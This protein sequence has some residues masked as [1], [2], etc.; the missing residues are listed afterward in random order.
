MTP[1]ASPS[2]EPVPPRVILLLV[3]AT[4]GTAM[5]AIVPMSY[6]LAVRIEQLAPGRPD[7]LGVTL[8]LGAAA[9][10]VVAPVTGLLSDRTR[11]RWG[12]RR[13]YTVGGAL[14]GVASV[15]LLALAPNV[16]VLA[17]AWMLGTAAWN[18]AAGSVANWQADHLAPRQRG[19]V[20]GI[21]GLVMQ[22]A[23]VVG[24]AL[25]GIV[26]HSALFVFGIPAIGGL[27]CLAPFAVVVDDS[28]TRAHPREERL[29]VGRVLRS[30]AFSPRAFPDFTWNWCGRF[31][32]FMGVMLTSSFTV[33]FYAQR[34]ELAVSAVAGLLALSSGLSI[35]TA[36][37]GSLG[38]GWLSDRVGRR[39]PVVLAGALV[40]ATG[41]ALLA[42]AHDVPS[43]IT[44][45][46]VT[47][48]GVA[49]FSAPAQALTLDVLPN[50]ETEAGRYMAITMFSQKIPGAIAPLVAPMIL[51]VGAAAGASNFALLY[52]VA[53]CCAVA[54]GVV[55]C[56]GVRG[57]R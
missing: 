47:S 21:T 32:F 54:G 4:F 13:P 45:T 23:P 49:L 38:G 16:A 55:V 22:V 12:R 2:S 36:S 15:P 41:S 56:A 30:Y 43:L 20:A 33:V 25:V 53:A 6:S 17:M 51:G 34:L 5:A 57:T 9:T 26:P 29:T 42:F 39:R 10:L 35:V 46:L 44:G 11:S 24:I 37:I 19:R 14:V 1:P 50:R 7:L 31:L 3:V 48:L 27:L 8:G 28:D 40:F 52:A 18:T